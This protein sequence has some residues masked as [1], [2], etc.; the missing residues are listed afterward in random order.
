[1]RQP[2]PFYRTAQKAWY[3]SIDR[4]QILLGKGDPKSP[5]QEVWDKYYA[6]M[7][8]RLPTELS[9]PVCRVVGMFLSWVETHRAANSYEWY[10]RH[11]TSFVEHIGEKL[12]LDKLKK[13]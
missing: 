7:G 5:P 10:R 6:L 2:K 8:N 9:T 4:K 12:T 13:S 11:L 3:V 1:M